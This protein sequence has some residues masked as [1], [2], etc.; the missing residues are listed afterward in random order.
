[1]N[2]R[3]FLT[4]SATLV[5]TGALFQALPV[6]ARAAESSTA[7]LDLA[8]SPEVLAGTFNVDDKAATSTMFKF[9]HHHYLA[10]PKAVLDNPPDAGFSTFTSRVVA[11]LGIAKA[12]L[13]IKKEHH[14]HEVLISKEQLLNM[15]DGLM[16][17]VNIYSGPQVV[18]QFLFNG[19]QSLNEQAAALAKAAKANDYVTSL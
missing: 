16:V 17:V 8:P 7:G 3:N 13:E 12:E 18:H 4:R 2:R 15:R 6:K 5:L 19:P 10:V 1:M 14:F 9:A 11:A